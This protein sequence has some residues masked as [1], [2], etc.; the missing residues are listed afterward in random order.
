MLGPTIKQPVF[1]VSVRVRGKQL[2]ALVD[3][4]ASTNFI[5]KDA[6]D[7]LCIG[8]VH[9]TPYPLSVANGSKMTTVVERTE[10]LS[11]AHQ[12]HHE[13]L[14]LD[15]ISM[16]HDVILG[17][18]W[19][20]KHN[21]TIDW[22]ARTMTFDRCQC[23]QDQR[24]TARHPLKESNDSKKRYWTDR[25]ELS[26]TERKPFV[27]IKHQKL[28]K[29]PT[30]EPEV[31]L[32]PKVHQKWK[33]LFQEDNGAT[34]LPAHKPWDHEIILEEGKEPTFGPLYKQS[35]RER[36]ET[37]KYIDENLKKGFIRKSQSK[38]AHPVLFA[39][40]KN[41]KLRMCVDYRK[42]NNITIKNRYPLP[43]IGELQDQLVGSKWFT[44]LDLRGAYNLIRIKEGDEWKTAFR[45]SYGLYEYRVMPFGL[46]NA[47]ATCQELVNDT[48]R[49]FLG[50]F[51]LAYLDDIIIFSQ[52]K[53]EHEKHVNQVLEALNDRD[54]R[55]AP[56]KCD[57]HKQDVEFLGFRI[58]VSGIQMDPKKVQSLKEWPVPGSVKEVQQFLGFANY[59][60]RFI[61]NYSQVAAPLTNLTKKETN[62]EWGPVQQ[63]AFDTLIKACSKDPV[64]K[65]FDPALDSRI[66]SDASDLAIGA[67]LAQQYDK[68]WHPVAYFSRKM[69]PAEQ[70]YDIHDKELLAIVASMKHWRVY[71]ESSKKLTVLTDHKN[72]LTFTSTKELNRRQVR[73]SEEL[74]Q[75]KF[76]IERIKGTDN[77]RA[78]ALSRRQDYMDDKHIVNHSILKI[79]QDGSLMPNKV[80]ELNH[81]LAILEDEDEEYPVVHGKLTVKDEEVEQCIKLHHDKELAGH[82]GV[83][84][85]VKLIQRTCYFK[86]M[87]KK[88]EQYIK[89]C[90]H[91]QQN[92]HGTHTKYGMI[93]LSKPETEPWNHITMDFI[94]KL[95][96]SR[97]PATGHHYDS[98]MVVVDKLTKYSHFIPFK[99]ACDAET[100][101]HI[102]VD[103]VIRYHGIPKAITSDRDKLFTSNYWRT[104]IGTIGTRLRLSTSFHPQTDGQTE[105]SNQTLEQ[106][107]RHYVSKAQNNWVELLP[108]AELAINN[109]ESETTGLS[110][111]FANFGKHPNMFMEPI[112]AVHAE[113]AL[114]A[115]NKMIDLHG[116]LNK[117][118]E[119]RNKTT[120]LQANRTRRNGPQLKEGDKVY[121]LTK[122]L[123]TRL[124]SKKLDNVRVGPFLIEKVK[125]PVNYQ[126]ALPKDAK[127]HP[128]FHI[129]LLEPA[130][131]ETPVQT[132]F[133]F[134]TQEEDTFE[135]EK[136]LDD[137]DGQHFLVK[138][139]GY[140]D[141][142]NTWEPLT[143]LTNCRLVLTQ[144]RQRKRSR[145]P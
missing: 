73:W 118:I 34:A 40:K 96:A 9:T 44:T 140:A 89:R 75:Y 102:L 55:V 22:N 67:C 70:N 54:L 20:A 69:T 139:K 77:V 84:K 111:F 71:A 85:T 115:A 104:L 80:Y 123:K 18:P 91:C 138:W 58:G 24:R 144:Y 49:L 90:V 132:Q 95:P 108:I 3:S 46:T 134:E 103:K 78:D 106:Y 5:S 72:L 32:I 29:V 130:D 121:L 94:V 81:L 64:L 101:G 68:H 86:N 42:L 131:A 14:T 79:N 128:V 41:G 63:R 113:K 143:N 99:E 15:I 37:K 36:D 25:Q 43:N 105:R 2:K 119:K 116:Q 109:H 21:P 7:R 114:V 16:R 11:M 50:D 65:I 88:V 19:L 127:I 51:A 38:V 1:T 27:K 98:I 107:L 124:P 122:N 48:L 87:K 33:K 56:E 52:T 83:S 74:G 23:G 112:N 39:P 142:E 145:N 6:V 61:R 30:K 26:N 136:I 28:E 100:L 4:G 66:E 57:W 93:Q 8:V 135:V 60:R 141:T 62:F 117:N 35:A 47:P 120:E 110:P 45:T 76:T 125:G 53:E 126:L 17:T 13:E 10:T 92:K 133:H 59:N 129:S 97:E 137:K 82:P 31:V 12:S